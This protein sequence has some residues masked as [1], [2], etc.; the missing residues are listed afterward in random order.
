MCIMLCYIMVNM[1]LPSADKQFVHSVFD[2]ALSWFVSHMR[3]N[4]LE[5][6]L[7]LITLRTNLFKSLYSILV[8]L[9]FLSMSN[10][11]NFHSVARLSNIIGSNNERSPAINVKSMF[12][13]I[14][15][16]FMWRRRRRRRHYKEE[17][18]RVGK[19]LCV[20]F[21]FF[22]KYR[23][24][25]L[26]MYHLQMQF[27]KHCNTCLMRFYWCNSLAV[28]HLKKFHFYYYYYYYCFN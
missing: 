6:L 24:R 18:R 23:L 17:V 10:T 8:R 21:F 19:M 26:F 2:N 9:P 13:V 28:L 4:A 7:G 11:P 15:P 22:N 5:H 12:V 27:I 14:R 1:S 20:Y 16:V 3:M 25:Y